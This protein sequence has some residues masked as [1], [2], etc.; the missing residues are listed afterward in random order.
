[1]SYS[2]QQW[3]LCMNQENMDGEYPYSPDLAPSD[4]FLF[5]NMK[6]KLGWEAVSD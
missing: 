2:G 3:L 6:K 4:Y 1:M 5:T